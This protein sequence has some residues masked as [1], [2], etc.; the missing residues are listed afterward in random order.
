[1]ANSGGRPE[2]VG[3]SERE[4]QAEQSV[5]AG[6]VG[7]FR[8]RLCPAL[9]AALLGAVTAVALASPVYARPT[10][11]PDTG[12][13]PVPAGGL[14]L[15][16]ASP[17]PGATTPPGFVSST[18]TGP[19]A[20]Q[21][22]AGE[23]E[24]AILGQE[25]LQVREEKAQARATLTEAERALQEARTATLAAQ[26]KAEAAAALALKDA[27]ALPPGEYGG[28]LHGLGALA[29][30]HRG[31]QPSVG[32]D[33]AG[34]EVALTTSAEHAAYA[35]YRDALTL[36]ESLRSRFTT[37][38]GTYRQRESALVA[39]KE[40][41]T[42]QLVAIERQ[43][44][45]NE[46]RIGAGI[47]NT[48]GLTGSAAHPRALAAVRFALTQLGKPYRWGAEGP[49]RYDC[50][51]LIWAA[52]RSEGADYR[53][54]PRVSRDQYHA[55]RSRTVDRS[56]LL[57]GDLI[58]FA[59]GSRWTSIH[60]VGM[61]IGNGRMVHSPTTGDV[62]KVSTVWWSR[63]YAATRVIREV[64]TPTPTPTPRPP[65]P[66]PPPRPPTP[67]P[68]PTPT[69]PSPSPSPSPTPSP[70]STPSPSTDPSTGTPPTG[71]ASGSPE[72]APDLTGDTLS[73]GPQPD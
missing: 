50:S 14:R 28:D 60:H 45:A 23:T 10:T 39:L 53:S 32:T 35:A 36:T 54:L 33:A 24:V 51:G 30:L 1:M 2:Q 72:P 27:A 69:E 41:N 5:T 70:T 56:A 62:V 57:P 16:G 71:L 3:R 15:P 22:Y 18:V 48:P 43:R 68:T 49:H 58:F 59:S 61:Y 29:R 21:I 8:P 6:V 40:R 46:Q 20:A 73:A 7:G 65:T 25:L 64:P 17:S 19:L 42:E 47:V 67:T 31:L 11:V 12:S 38:E 4:E 52:Y 55:T 13:R 9:W 26:R 66:R 44:E 63:F 37:L 34:R